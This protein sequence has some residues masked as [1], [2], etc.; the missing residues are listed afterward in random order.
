MSPALVRAVAEAA[1]DHGAAIPVLPVAETL[2]RLDGQRVGA[3]VDRTDVV[4]AQT[5][6]GVR[7]SL[8]SPAYAAFPPDGP[9]TWTDEA[10]LLEACRIPVQAI[11]GEATNLK[12]TVPVDLER[13]H[14][15]LT[16][17]SC[18]AARRARRHRA[19]RVDRRPR[20]SRHDSHP[21]GPG[22]PLMLGGLRIDG[23]PRLAGIPMATSPCMPSPTHC[24]ARPGWAIWAGSSR[25]THERPSGSTAASCLPRWPHRSAPPAGVPERRHDD[26]RRTSRL[27]KLLPEMA[28][29]IAAILGMDTGAVNVKAS[30]GN[31]T[32]QRARAGPSRPMPSSRC[33]AIWTQRRRAGVTIR[34]HDTMAGAMREFVPLEPGHVRIYSCGPTVYGPAHVGNFRSFLFAD[35][36]V[37]YL[38]YRGCEVTWVMNM[39]DVD[40]KIIKGARPRAFRSPRFRRRTRKFLGDDMTSACSCPT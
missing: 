31:L 37:R 26:R 5:P 22:A 30:T 17:A 12:V 8:L 20:R 38:R 39:T 28:G 9:E 16:A 14:A 2:K 7:R 35:L 4:A 29:E 23:A 32:A 24:W 21:F 33:A 19:R 18:P 40:D 34:L 25:P 13:A 3:T 1:A 27:A 6:Q 11:S 10:S 15:M 36:L